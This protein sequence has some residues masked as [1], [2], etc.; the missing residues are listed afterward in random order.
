MARRRHRRA[1]GRPFRPD[2]VPAADRR[3]HRRGE[4][5]GAPTAT[6]DT[7]KSMGFSRGASALGVAG[8]RRGGAPSAITDAAIGTRLPALVAAAP[9]T[10][11][12]VELARP[13]DRRA[14]HEPGLDG[15]ARVDHAVMADAHRRRAGARRPGPAGLRRARPARHGARDAPRRRCSPRPRPASTGSLRGNR[16]T[17]LDDSDISATRH[18]RGFVGRGAG[19]RRRPHRDLRLRRRRAPGTGRRR[20]GRHHR[21]TPA[22]MG[23]TS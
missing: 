4:A 5:R 10:S 13:R 2:Q 22:A 12:G 23:S 20:P 17:M 14:R 15:A 21:R 9:A 8:A 18:A 6:R 3:A 1:G 19:G 7:L 16:H 11:A